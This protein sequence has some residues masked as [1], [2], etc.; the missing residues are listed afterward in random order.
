MNVSG[1]AF[2]LIWFLL[3]L[4]PQADPDHIPDLED[5][6][7]TQHSISEGVELYKRHFD[8]LFESPQYISIIVADLEMADIEIGFAAASQFGRTEMELPELAEEALAIAAVNG[9]FMHGK[10]KDMNS[11]ILKIDNEIFPFFQEEPEELSFVGSSVLVYS[12]SYGWNIVK[13]QCD[14]Y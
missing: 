2:R 12:L 4:L 5:S 13:R 14:H 1:K 9:G 11:G 3:L 10:K 8:D 6:G 7:W